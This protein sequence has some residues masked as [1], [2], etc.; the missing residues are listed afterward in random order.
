MTKKILIL[1]FVTAIVP[2]VLFTELISLLCVTLQFFLGIIENVMRMP[3]DRVQNLISENFKVQ[4]G[5]EQC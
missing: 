3:L 4:E 2:V 5:G 1:V